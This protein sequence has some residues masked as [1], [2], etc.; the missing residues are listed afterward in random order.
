MHITFIYNGAENIGIEYLSSFLKSKGHRVSLLFD[1]ATFSGDYIVNN[2]V[3]S[4]IFSIDKKILEKISELNPD[5]IGFSSF[6]GNYR[7]CLNLAQKIKEIYS[8]PIVFGGVHTT[9]LPEVVLTNNFVDYVIIGEAEFAF[10]DLIKHLENG[11]N[12]KE[13]L[14]ISNICFK[15]EDRIQIN[16][17]RPYIN[18]LDT[19]PFPDKMLFYEKIPL[20]EKKYFAITSRGC[21]FKCTY[22]SNSMYHNLY[23]ENRR[24]L[25]RRSPENVIDELMLVKKKG[26]S[27][28]VIFADDVF[29]QDQK[30]LE[31]FVGIYRSKVGLPFYC[32]AHPSHITREK[33]LLLKEGGCYLVGMGIQSGSERVRKQIFHRLGTN[34][35]IIESIEQLKAVGI[36]VSVDNIFGAPTEN[37]DDLK[38]SLKLYN[39]IKADN[40]WTFWLT[41]YPK[42]DI[43]NL[44][45]DHKI[46]TDD[47]IK[48]IGAGF[49]GYAH[50]TGSISDGEIDFY[51]NYELRFRLRSFIH[52]DILYNFLSKFIAFIPFKR[53]FSKVVLF[54]TAI[55]NRDEKVLYT[56]R[57]LYTKKF[58]P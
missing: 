37:E 46:L 26:I 9:A 18:D 39:R 1:P 56:L 28:L 23:Q 30:W 7:W 44:A 50:D 14:N 15:Y 57:L 19:V 11:A 33:V 17:P 34:E 41:Y 49:V 12:Q 22:C 21:L 2:K 47:D 35:Q 31:D 3:L 27:K 51:A 13:L 36:Q 38:E 43:I 40:I 25:R 20:L 24:H 48:K 52:S 53:T 29:T 58:V 55:K 42:T 32:C 16:S 5:L 8:I 45:I 4:T 54:L 10:L 6:T